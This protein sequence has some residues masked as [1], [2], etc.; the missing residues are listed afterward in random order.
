MADLTNAYTHKTDLSDGW[1]D[2]DVHNNTNETR[3]KA[4][5]MGCNII[6]YAFFQIKAKNFQ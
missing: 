6:E 4:L 2:Q 3:T 5:K 1:E